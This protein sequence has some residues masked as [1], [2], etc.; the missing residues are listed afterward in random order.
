MA[1]PLASCVISVFQTCPHATQD[2]FS[3]LLAGPT[4]VLCNP[5]QAKWSFQ[6][7]KSDHV[8]VLP[9]PL[10]NFPTHLRTSS[11]ILT[12]RLSSMAWLLLASLSSHVWTCSSS[13][14][15]W[16]CS[17]SPNTKAASQHLHASPPSACGAL[18]PHL[19]RAPAL[20]SSYSEVTSW[21]ALCVWSVSFP[22]P[23]CPMPH[24]S[25]A[26]FCFI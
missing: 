6:R 11:K 2:Q 4:L 18:P 19:L 10:M 26:L 13:S 1:S 21:E 20:L 17:H 24:H 3:S 8:A 5:Q 23:P 7:R 22:P 14:G 25:L 12:K 9:K 16:P 15:R